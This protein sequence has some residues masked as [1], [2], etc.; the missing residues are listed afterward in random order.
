MIS[1]R[2]PSGNFLL[3]AALLAVAFHAMRAEE[4]SATWQALNEAFGHSV[5]ADDSLWDDADADVAGRLGWPMESSTPRDAS[6]RL[7][8]RAGERV[9]GARPFSLALYGEGGSASGLSLVFANKGDIDAFLEMDSDANARQAARQMREAVKEFEKQVKADE[10][11]I[12]GK[13]TAVLGEPMGTSFG[14]SRKMRERVQRWD[15]NGHSI[16]LAAPKGEYVSVRVI[17]TD[18]ADNARPVRIGDDALRDE[19]AQR[20]EQRPNGDVIIK[21]IPMVDQG[22]KGYCVPA[23]WERVLRYMGIP[24]DMYVLAMAG[25]TGPGGGT[26]IAGIVA[27]AKELVTRAGRRIE[28]AGSRLSIHSVKK[29]IDRGLPIMWTMYSMDDVNREINA[30]MGQRDLAVGAEEWNEALEDARKAARKIQKDRESGHVCMIIGYN[31]ETDELAISDSWGRN[32]EERWITLE[33][34]NAI[35]QGSSLVINL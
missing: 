20:I 35:T 26:S 4:N 25:N 11:T 31:D 16:L 29:Y 33:E 27:G 22:P 9:L 32:Y 1:H 19:L 18:L 2:T 10:E 8:P 12:A 24:A 17:P 23:T 34:A 7:Y 3:R 6:Y 21:T 28:N 13:L 30:R 5:W 15:W 14:A